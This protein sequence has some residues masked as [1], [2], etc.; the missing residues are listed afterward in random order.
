[1]VRTPLGCRCSQG[2]WCSGERPM[3]NNLIVKA[4][5]IGKETGMK[6]SS[7]L[8]AAAALGAVLVASEPAA[9]YHYGWH[10]AHWRHGWHGAHWRYGWHGAHWRYGWRGAYLRSRWAWN[11]GWGW[12]GGWPTY[13]W[14]WGYP[15]YGYGLTAAATAP[16]AVAA[17]STAPL[18]TGRSVAASGNYCAT[19]V[20][21][22]LL[23]RPGWVGT[24]CSCKVRGRARGIVE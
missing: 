3:P 4:E 22:C 19:P 9:A 20:K 14:G 2:R 21:T 24:G 11:R 17:A 6:R 10:R 12:A 1:M 15:Y 16:I 5:T 23:Y 13:A 8:L 7:L 18:M